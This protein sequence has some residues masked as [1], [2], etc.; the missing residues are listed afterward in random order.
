MP[1]RSG[2]SG[3]RRTAPPPGPKIRATVDYFAALGMPTS[4]GPCVGIQTPETLADMA[5]RCA[6]EGTRT[7]GT[8]RVL[9]QEDIRRIYEAANR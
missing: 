7:I 1:G 2:T 4:F 8:L 5:Y 3:R 9:E 6:Y